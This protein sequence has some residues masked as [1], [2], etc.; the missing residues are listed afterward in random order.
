MVEQQD[1]GKE[2]KRFH[3]KQFMHRLARHTRLRVLFPCWKVFTLLP[4]SSCRSPRR[5]R[6]SGA[7]FSSVVLVLRNGWNMWLEAEHVRVSTWN[8][9]L[10][11]CSKKAARVSTELE[12][13]HLKP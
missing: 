4:C 11:R 10:R 12:L 3:K 6:A 7:C 1:N 8:S 2:N 9:R 13:E 5:L